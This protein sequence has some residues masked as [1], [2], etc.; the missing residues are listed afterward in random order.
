MRQ[1]LILAALVGLAQCKD[2]VVESLRS[3]P[4]GWRKL[5]DAEPSHPLKLRIAMVQPNTALFEQTLYEVSDPQHAL[6]GQHLKRDELT[7]MMAPRD[8]STST[9]LT[10]L[11]NAGISES[12]VENDGEWVNLLVTVREAEDLLDAKFAMYG[13][14]DTQIEKVRALEYSVPEEVKE[15]ITFIAP[16]I[17]FGQPKPQRSQIIEVADAHTANNKAAVIPPQNLNV[18]ACNATITPECLRALYRVG[19]YQA[20]PSKRSLFGVSGYLEVRH[21]VKFFHSAERILKV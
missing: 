18:T 21:N 11:R 13:Y 10:W 2:I 4:T 6:Y 8:E 15:H 16:I 7:S 19:S 12:K 20:D 9:V 1:S 5:R 17:R 3:V 14:L